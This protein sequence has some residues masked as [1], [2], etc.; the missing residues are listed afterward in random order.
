MPLVHRLRPKMF[1]SV[2][3]QIVFGTSFV[4]IAILAATTYFIIDQKQK[5]INFD[6]FTNAVSFAE[7]T[8]E[9]VVSNYEKN[10]VEQAFANFD[11]ELADIYSLNEDIPGVSIFNYAGES[12]YRPKGDVFGQI[13]DED[14][15]RIQSVTPSAKTTDSRVVYLDTSDDEIRYANLNGKTIAPI[16]S[17]EQIVDI[18][19][20]FRDPN[21][22]LRSFSI[23]YQVSYEALQ[24]RIAET[25]NNMLILALFG[26][27]IALFIGGVI[28]GR[29]TSPIKRLTEG[30]LKIGSGDLTTRIAVSSK[31]EIGKLA[32]TFNQMTQDLDRS[33]KSLIQ[34]EKQ[35]RELEL[36]GEIQRELLP[37]TLPKIK[38]LDIAASLISATEVGGDCYDFLVSDENNLIFYVGDVTGHGVPAGLVSAI[39]NALIPALL[40]H[41]ETTEELIAHLNKILKQKTRPNVFMSMVMAHWHVNEARLGYTQAGHDPILIY[42]AAEKKVE[43]LSKGGMAL[44]MTD[45][46]SGVV[47]TEKIDMAV[48]DVAVLYTDGIPEAWKDEK[49]TYGM[50]RFKASVLKNS[51]LQ[52][53]QQIH[54]ALIADVRAFMADYRQVD[55][56]TLIVAKRTQ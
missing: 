12:L 55:D 37:T 4:I 43:E 36:A 52:T 41:Y 16:T 24:D 15:E 40:E 44:G 34:K 51:Q 56:I 19:Y 33:T 32:D 30:A 39:N 5:E 31:S 14:L 48:G 6:I 2:K 50:E 42:R 13:S 54:D 46:I 8:H 28:A 11:R 23:R 35:T 47:Q 29:I 38:N 53:A 9:R 10:Y 3:S 26:I 22:P 17:A 21:N 49:E 45:D 27:L 18:I 20:P 7:L 1:K 25:R